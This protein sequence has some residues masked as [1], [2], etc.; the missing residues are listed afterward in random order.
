[1]QL[2]ATVFHDRMLTQYTSC[3]QLNS[4]QQNKKNQQQEKQLRWPNI[5]TDIYY[6]FIVYLVF[7]TCYILHFIL[8]FNILYA[9]P[10]NLLLH[11]LHTFLAQQ[12]FIDKCEYF[13]CVFINCICRHMCEYKNMQRHEKCAGFTQSYS[14]RQF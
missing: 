5:K 11:A 8:N 1:M 2:L 10:E 9:T 3:V 13:Q 4:K 12:G 6:N 7:D 14:H